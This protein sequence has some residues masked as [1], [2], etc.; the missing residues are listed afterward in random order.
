MEK[1][2]ISNQM[3]GLIMAKGSSPVAIIIRVSVLL[4]IMALFLSG[5]G[6]AADCGAGEGPPAVVIN[7]QPLV[8][9]VEPLV[10]NDH[11]LVPA[12]AVC[13]ALGAQLQWDGLQ[14]KA[15]IIRGDDAVELWPERNQASKNGAR[16]DLEVEPR[17]VNER[18]LVPLR[19]IS[20]ALG[21]SVNW[22][23]AAWQAVI[24]LSDEEPVPVIERQFVQKG[25]FGPES[26]VETV[27]GNAA[28]TVS[29]VELQN[30]VI[31]GD[32]YITEGVGG[33]DVALNNVI[34]QGR[35]VVRGG[36]ADSIH[37]DGGQ[38]FRIVIEQTPSGKV[39]IV[40]VNTSGIPVTVADDAGGQEIILEGN[41]D[42]V[43]IK[44]P[45]VL[46]K[47]R[48]GTV[49][50]QVAV[51]SGLTGVAM[52]LAD[53]SGITSMIVNSPVNVTG[54][55]SIQTVTGTQAQQSSFDTPPV[56][57]ITDQPVVVTP[58]SDQITVVAIDDGLNPVFGESS[59]NVHLL[60]VVQDSGSSAS[61]SVSKVHPFPGETVTATVDDIPVFYELKTLRVTPV[62]GSTANLN[63]IS[64]TVY[65][66]I[67]PA[68]DVYIYAEVAYVSPIIAI[69]NTVNLQVLNGTAT[70]KA[71]ADWADQGDKITIDVS[72]IQAGK[73]MEALAV[74]PRGTVMVGTDNQLISNSLP[75]TEAVSGSRYTFTMPDSPVDVYVILHNNHH[76]VNLSITNAGTAMNYSLDKTEAGAGDT[77]TFKCKL[78][79]TAASI[80]INVANGPSLRLISDPNWDCSYDFVM[81]DNDVKIYVTV[82][83]ATSHR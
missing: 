79:A 67:M 11:L 18:V 50:K 73:H 13:E 52:D 54:N 33:G 57:P 16:L 26:G 70:V 35:L 76:Q 9:E 12:R 64:D 75:V 28:V 17:I 23:P 71:S 62:D 63:K 15:T 83:Y 31:A 80:S 44:A 10:A 39:R 41:F 3:G 59:L 60:P 7:G 5:N 68:Y 21:A 42:I 58:I 27:N 14:Q 25:T 32:L 24:T 56:V 47:T 51:D 72:N 77:V 2:D 69:G 65:T 22:D 45:G 20:D 49:I 82:N 30:L 78:P 19:F 61:I 29:G 4:Y 46:I 81:P 48:T 66:F 34:V 40:A 43:E 53:N 37:I 74:I 8:S 6:A 55:G 1:A 38:Y 36:G